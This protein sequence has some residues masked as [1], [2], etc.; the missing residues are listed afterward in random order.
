MA[1]T[2]GIISMGCRSHYF[3]QNDTKTRKVSEEGLETPFEI[4][5]ISQL[6]LVLVYG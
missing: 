4:V 1:C 3:A 5:S 6:L 2:S